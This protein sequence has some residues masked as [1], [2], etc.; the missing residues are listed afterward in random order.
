MRAVVAVSLGGR[1]FQLEDDAHAALAQYLNTAEQ[2]LAD[3][4]DR[5]EILADLEQAIADKS[6]RFLTAHKNVITRAEIEQVIG[7]MGPVGDG[8]GAGVGASAASPAG[9]RPG[10]SGSASAPG[11][12]KRLY[13]ISDGA[14]LSG[15]CMGLAV[16]YGVDVALVRLIFVVA[17]LLTGGLAVLAYLALMFIVPYADTPEQM[18]AAGGVPFNARMLVEEWKRKAAEFAGA[19]AYAARSDGSPADRIRWRREWR[20]TREQWRREWRANRAQWRAYHRSAR[21]W[22]PPPGQAPPLPPLAALAAGLS[23]AALGILLGLVTLAW[24]LALLS[25]FANDTVFGWS[26]AHLPLW[27]AVVILLLLYQL[28][29]GSLRALRHAH[30]PYFYPGYYRAHAVS[31]ALG[32]LVL[33]AVLLWLLGTHMPAVQHFIAVL[34]HR[35]TLFWQHGGAQAPAAAPPAH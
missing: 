21:D 11:A 12:P 20:R 10:T 27:A 30:S 7:E 6:E 35:A 2:A 32:G 31:D 18:A 34:Q 29:A 14:L 25:L 17:A 8:S 16:Y 9:G 4:P 19:A 28:L 26:F 24:V 15:V 13:Q 5:A 23:R 1:V 22:P 3:N 33:F